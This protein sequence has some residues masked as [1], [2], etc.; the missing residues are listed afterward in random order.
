MSFRHPHPYAARGYPVP[1]HPVHP[2]GNRLPYPYPMFPMGYVSYQ[3]PRMAPP[4]M[5]QWPPYPPAPGRGPLP[6]PAPYPVRPP[7]GMPGSPPPLWDS[8]ESP[9]SPWLDGVE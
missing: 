4:Y 8:P 1:D 7:M 3:D 2:G 6:P 5:S 9:E